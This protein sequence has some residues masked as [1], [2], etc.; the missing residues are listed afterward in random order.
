MKSKFLLALMA[1]SLGV[2]AALVIP[3]AW[4]GDEKFSLSSGFDSNS[5]QYQ[6][7]PWVFKL[8][9]PA[10]LSGNVTPE[11]GGNS[12][13]ATPGSALSGLS[14]TEAAASY[15]IYAGSN[16][17][18][19]V[20]LTGKVKVRQADKTQ[21]FSFRQNDYAAQMD[22]YQSLDKFTAKGSL[23]STVLGGSTGIT[24]NPLLYGSFGG[25]YQL[26]E[27]TS[28]GIDMRLSHDPSAMQQELSAYVSYKL[29]NSFKARGYVLRG[30]SNGS[31][32]SAIGGQ[33]YYGF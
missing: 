3:A 4:A 21:L 13:G 30:F 32:N 17:T 15:N 10:G 26:T 22:V 20:N 24:L 6:A 12:I 29:D 1:G 2:I 19:Q 7:G 16:S 9:A 31:P 28:T 18:P 5:K 27:K 33:V 11:R 14:N 23:G 8:A 25:I